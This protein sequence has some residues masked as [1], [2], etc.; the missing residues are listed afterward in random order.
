[1]HAFRFERDSTQI[2][3]DLALSRLLLALVVL[4]KNYASET[5]LY[6]KDS[7]GVAPR[8]LEPHYVCHS[9]SAGAVA[10]A[11]RSTRGAGDVA[12]GG[13]R[14]QLQHQALHSRPRPLCPVMSLKY[15]SIRFSP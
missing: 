3:G 6:D 7:S 8:H 2:E 5:Y 10:V 11:D 15:A 9:G 14:Y 4:L 12:V 13:G 1:M